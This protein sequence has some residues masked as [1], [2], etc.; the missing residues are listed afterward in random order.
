MMVFRPATLVFTLGTQLYGRSVPQ[1]TCLFGR[2]PI[3][4]RTFFT[5]H[6][7]EALPLTHPHFFH[8]IRSYPMRSI[9]KELSRASINKAKKES[10]SA[11]KLQSTKGLE[12][13]R[14]K[15]HY[16]TTPSEPSSSAASAIPKEP[17]SNSSSSQARQEV[18][19]SS[20]QP[21]Q[22]QSNPQEN[23][24]RLKD[25]AKEAFYGATAFLS[26]WA[27][28][29]YQDI[30]QKLDELKLSIGNQAHDRQVALNAMAAFQVYPLL[31]FTTL[32]TDKEHQTQQQ[33]QSLLTQWQQQLQR[34]EAALNA[35][36]DRLITSLSSKAPE[37]TGLNSVKDKIAAL[38]TGLAQEKEKQEFF[39]ALHTVIWLHKTRQYATAL[40]QLQPL[41]RQLHQWKEAGRSM[42]FPL[43]Y[44]LAVAYNTQ[45]K[46]E[47]CLS[48]KSLSD[49]EF[50]KHSDASLA[51]YEKA[52]SLLEKDSA[53]PKELAIL[54]SSKGY[55]LGDRGKHKDASE[56]HKE[57]DTLKPEDEHILCGKGQDLYDAELA[58]KP[59]ERE[60]GNL[61]K[62]YAYLT[63]ALRI[64]DQTPN[65]TPNIYVTRGKIQV[66][67]NNL[68][69]AMQDFDEALKL[70]KHHSEANLQKAQVLMRQ[71]QCGPMTSFF[72]TGLVPLADRPQ[73]VKQKLAE[74]KAI[75]DTSGSKCAL[76][77][78]DALFSPS[79]T[80]AK[81]TNA[82]PSSTAS[83]PKK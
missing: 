39:Q 13:H 70:D 78:E 59:A 37:F 80:A 67:L 83:S 19:S 25:Y 74:L 79:D 15:V 71:S 36:N 72:K 69:S 38:Q 12:I 64:N 18:K 31:Y 54:K 23:S 48:K 81:E 5:Y 7:Q 29:E 65:K 3:Q 11:L 45:A 58:K 55:L 49:E 47:A 27:F 44:L 42:A 43:P 77:E 9:F 46:L 76:P 40:K 73:A 14:T 26:V 28:N 4:R 20:Q 56:L 34:D 66:A 8:T 52:I 68:D 41:I 24:K 62:A 60:R 30:H 17:A 75:K 22:N 33:E 16:S 21:G 51:S 61:D 1:I 10:V 82:E 6:Y 53:F 2:V 50:W 32:L 35:L 63:Q 57:S